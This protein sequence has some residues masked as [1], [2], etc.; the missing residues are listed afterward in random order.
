MKNSFLTAALRARRILLTFHY[1]GAAALSLG[2]SYL[3]RLDF[4][5]DEAY[6]RQFLYALI[7]MVPLKV[8]IVGSNGFTKVFRYGVVVRLT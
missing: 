6:E 3:I 8:V 4:R 5:L 7:W 1:A 2:L